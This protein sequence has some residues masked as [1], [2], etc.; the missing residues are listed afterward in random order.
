MRTWLAALL[1]AASASAPALAA[2]DR[3]PQPVR[4]GDLIG[5]PLVGPT[6][7]QPLLGHVEAVDRTDTGPA[8]RIRTSSLFPWNHRTVDVPVSAVTLVG[9]LVALIDLTPDQLAVL[10]NAAA[11]APLSPAE[12]IQIGLSRPFH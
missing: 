9:E 12:T 3:Y 1:L 11:A 10:P 6:E 5:R 8:L 4:A 7:A 2:P